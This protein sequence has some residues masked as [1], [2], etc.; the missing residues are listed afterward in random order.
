MRLWS[1][2]P[3]YLDKAGL[4]ALWREA[5]LAKHVLEG[6]T[7]GYCHHPQLIRFRDCPQPLRAINFYLHHVYL[8]ACNRGYCFDKAKVGVFTE[9]IQISV[10]T[11]QIAYEW[12]HL[13]TKLKLRDLPRYQEVVKVKKVQPHPLFKV[14]KGDIEAW[15][16]PK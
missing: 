16:R 8:E 7:K 1:I 15:E 3:R 10:S 5:L 2:H 11:G 14:V 9:A 13:L 6:K 4:V 12:Q